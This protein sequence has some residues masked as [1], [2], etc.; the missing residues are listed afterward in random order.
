MAS[1]RAGWRRLEG[2]L[3]DAQIAEKYYQR[4]NEI[5]AIIETSAISTI[6][7]LQRIIKTM[8]IMGLKDRIPAIQLWIED[9]QNLSSALGDPIEKY[10]SLQFDLDQ[11]Q[12]LLASAD[13][14]E[15]ISFCSQ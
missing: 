6:E 9:L 15:N 12:H 4:I 11:I 2:Q 3:S 7:S 1:W 13:N 8:R 10:L 14:L 5:S